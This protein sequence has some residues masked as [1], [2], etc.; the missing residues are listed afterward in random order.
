MPNQKYDAFNIALRLFAYSK[1][2]L[3]Y[4]LEGLT[5]A[6]LA[7]QSKPGLCPIGWHAGHI[8]AFRG[9]LMWF[10]DAEPDWSSLG[11]FLPFGYGS[12]PDA[13][14]TMIPPWQEL[15][16]AIQEDWRLFRER[17]Q[18]FRQADFSHAVPLN[19]PDG[20]TLFEM[21][22]RTTWHADLHIGQ[23]CMLRELLNKPIF[24]RPPFGATLRRN[25]SSASKTGW[26][27]IISMADET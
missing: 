9:A 25:W 10:F 2:S 21:S 17:F 13:T 4:S 26:E 24:P 6:D 8:G 14:L 3:L 27:R 1:A 11:V 5:D 19:N 23:I 22:H 7:W 12:D 20:E 15:V 18:I 16:Q